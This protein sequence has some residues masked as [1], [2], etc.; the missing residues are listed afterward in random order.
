MSTLRNHLVTEDAYFQADE[1]L[2]SGLFQCS[3]R[4]Y[5]DVLSTNTLWRVYCQLV[6]LREM[7]AL[8][9]DA[10]RQGRISFYMTCT[11]EEAIHFGAASALENGDPVLAQYR[12]QG[13][14]MW[15][16]FTLNQFMN[17]CFSNDLDLSKGRQMPIHYGC[18]AL[19]YHTISSPLGTQLPQ[20]V[21][22]AYRLK[23]MEKK[24]VAI[25]F[26]GE[27][28]AS[29]P[30]FHSAMNFA[31]ALKAPCLFFCRNNGYAISTP[32]K[33]QYVGDGIIGR[34]PGYGMAA[35]RVDGNDVVAVHAAV[36]AARQYALENNAPVLIEAMTYRIGH[37]STS[38]DSSAYRDVSQ[39]QTIQETTDP[40]Q[41]L[42][43][44]LKN[45]NW[46]NND[47]IE[48]I[49]HAERKAVRDA[50]QKAEKRP[51]PSLD[52]MFD[53]VYFD[54]PQHLIQ[55]QTQMLEHIAKYPEHYK[56]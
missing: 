56:Y 11:G 39:L 4:A 23:L 53:D 2:A 55:Q 3:E 7:D 37:H 14:L 16:G 46:I 17:Q 35:I 5:P 49:K 30:D 8:L 13:V 19:N 50:F 28:C 45:Y 26:F 9:L 34:A 21:G 40:L 33:E 20:A 42:E 10:Q 43:N 15:R 54:M 29:T 18:R 24:N 32:S 31:A 22:C 25:T 12:E 38:D 1:I 51:K 52:K 6:R 36:R 41:R 44:F 48:K 27:G 47:D